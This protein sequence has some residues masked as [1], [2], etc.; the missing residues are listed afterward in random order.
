MESLEEFQR[1]FKEEINRLT[2]KLKKFAD[3]R[4]FVGV[5]KALR[6]EMEEKE[7]HASLEDFFRVFTLIMVEKINGPKWGGHDILLNPLYR[8]M[9]EC[10]PGD[11]ACI[12]LERHEQ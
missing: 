2:E 8:S 5:L 4:E 6:E 10:G 11:D 9:K 1:H 3:D 12:L 7:F